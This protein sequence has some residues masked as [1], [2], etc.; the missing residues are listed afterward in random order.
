MGTVVLF[1]GIKRPGRDVNHLPPTNVEVRIS[2]ALPPL[3]FAVWAGTILSLFTL[4]A[5][6]LTHGIL[7]ARR[8]P[9]PINTNH[10]TQYFLNRSDDGT[11]S[12]GSLGFWTFSIVRYSEKNILET[13]CVRPQVKMT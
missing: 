4:V 7:I 11:L 13:G 1:Q 12:S 3:P 2:G 8:E 9:Q 6:V 5:T 10:M